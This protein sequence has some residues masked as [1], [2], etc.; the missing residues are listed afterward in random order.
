MVCK[1]EPLITTP[2]LEKSIFRKWHLWSCLNLWSS[3]CQR[4][5]WTW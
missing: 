2:P 5:M 4:V 1:R 3:K